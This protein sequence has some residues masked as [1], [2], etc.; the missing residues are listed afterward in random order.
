MASKNTEKNR[1]IM[2]HKYTVIRLFIFMGA[3][4]VIKSGKM[5]AF[6]SNV[7]TFPFF[8]FTTVAGAT[9]V[10]L[11]ALNDFTVEE[12][13]LGQSHSRETSLWWTKTTEKIMFWNHIQYESKPFWKESIWLIS[14]AG[15]V[16]ITSEG[17]QSPLMES[18]GNVY[19]VFLDMVQKKN[20]YGPKLFE[21]GENN[22]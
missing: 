10:A 20:F 3:N 19:F 14:K 12:V 21:L 18:G 4:K 11:R 17:N 13:K 1:I 16:I 15:T 7:C 8:W 5:P 2:S 6:T 22:F 9:I